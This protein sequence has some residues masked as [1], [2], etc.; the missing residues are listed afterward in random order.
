MSGFPKDP[1]LKHLIVRPGTAMYA[2]GWRTGRCAV[3]AEDFVY[4]D[5]SGSIHIAKAGMLTDG[6]TLPWLA[7]LWFDV[8]FGRY[9]SGY[10]LHDWYCIEARDVAMYVGTEQGQAL[11][12]AGDYLLPEML[13]NLAA[14]WWKQ[15]LALRAVR[16]QAT[17]EGMA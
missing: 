16:A 15:W 4:V 3:L 5:H 13:S 12:A 14:P 2:E 10:I 6:G 11:R 1:E 9:V 17:L 7:W 8:P